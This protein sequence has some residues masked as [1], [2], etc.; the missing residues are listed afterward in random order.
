MSILGKLKDEPGFD[1]L[2]AQM[3]LKVGQQ[4]S[5]YE[6][7]NK[8]AEAE[9]I[10]AHKLHASK[11]GEDHVKTALALYNL[12]HAVRRQH[13]NAESE[14]MYRQVLEIQMVHCAANHLDVLNTRMN[15][16]ISM[17][18]QKRFSEAIAE[19]EEVV[20]LHKARQ[21]DHPKLAIALTCLGDVHRFG[22][23]CSKAL[24]CY[25]AAEQIYS[26]TPQFEHR[27]EL[28]W[29]SLGKGLA[30]MQQGEFEEARRCLD[31]AKEKNK[32]IF[33]E[34]HI[35]F[36]IVAVHEGTWYRAQGQFPEAE[37][38]YAQ[39]SIIFEGAAS[40]YPVGRTWLQSLQ[41]LLDQKSTELGTPMDLAGC[42]PAG[43]A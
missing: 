23:D 20:N 10:L 24:E 14:T 38:C 41:E 43:S 25:A 27:N 35:A 28:A 40:F 33:Y 21:P 42:L 5:H 1:A 4:L 39:A 37:R 17:G 36:A 18:A 11:F 15:L 34:S 7:R 12:A 6:W 26:S 8:E 19:L 13:R 3:H 30:S 9:F 31:I 22:G 2:R 16:A 32:E 29:H